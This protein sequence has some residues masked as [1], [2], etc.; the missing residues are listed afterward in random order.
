MTTRIGMVKPSARAKA[1]RDVRDWVPT[2][3]DISLAKTGA[4]L[5]WKGGQRALEWLRQEGPLVVQVLDSRR[6]ASRY[7]LKLR[8]TNHAIHGIHLIRFRVTW[9]EISPQADFRFGD[10]APSYGDTNDTRPKSKT[11]EP[12]ASVDT[13][14]AF[15]LPV[16]V[17]REVGLLGRPSRLGSGEIDYWIL[18]LEAPS[19]PKQV[20]FALRL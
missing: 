14:V 2:P 10:K 3:A 6:D 9:P 15:E 18:N 12:A 1:Q 7:L 19:E 8:I 4:D 17:D 5:A 16:T 13:E 20:Q 11:V